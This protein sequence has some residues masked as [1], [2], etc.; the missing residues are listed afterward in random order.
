MTGNHKF[1][2]YSIW[3]KFLFPTLAI[4]CHLSLLGGAR[5]CSPWTFSNPLW[6]FPGS[7][8]TSPI[9]LW[10]TNGPFYAG[11]Q[12]LME[13]QRVD[14]YKFNSEIW[15]VNFVR[16]C[17]FVSFVNRVF[18]AGEFAGCCLISRSQPL[19]MFR[20]LPV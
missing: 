8:W 16:Q 6:L 18:L 4:C 1:I 12:S 13:L 14:G 20:P 2:L 9:C 10:N 3:D 7:L 11:G 17:S 5:P 19:L 15:F